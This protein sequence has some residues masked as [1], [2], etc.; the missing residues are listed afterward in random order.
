MTL[1]ALATTVQAQSALERRRPGA[2]PRPAPP[3]IRAE[4]IPTPP[5]TP[6]PRTELPP[7]PVAMP[8]RWRLVE[9]IG[10]NERWWDPYNQNTF[11]A[12]R[13]L[14][15]DHWFLNLNLLSASLFEGRGVPT[16]VGNQATDRPGELDVFGD[17][18][19][20]TIAETALFGGSL[21]KGDTTF[22]PPDYEFRIE[23]GANVNYTSV[24]ERGAINVNPDDGTTRLDGHIG[25][26]ELF[27]D[28]HLWNKSDDFDFDSLRVGIQAFNADFRG[29]LFDDR[30]LGVRLFGNFRKNRLQ[31]NLAW[32]R[33]LEKD[34]N[35]GLNRVFDPRQDDVFVANAFFQDL[36]VRGFQTEAVVVYNR[37]R[38]G[39][40]AFHFNENGFLERPAS[41]GL[42]RPH[43]YDVVYVG[44]GGDGHVGRL[45]LTAFAYGAFG[46]DEF[47]SIAGRKQ[48]LRAYLLASEASVDFD[49]YRV[50]VFAL[51]ASGDDDPFDGTATG[52]DAIFENPNFAGG[53]T[54]FFQRQ[55]VPLTGG[56]GVVLS[57]RNSLIP[58]LRSSKEQ[59]Q[60]SFVNPGIV[61][62]GLGADF[63][64][65]PELRLTTNVS[66]VAFAETAVLRTLRQ[67]RKVSRELGYDLSAAFVYRPWFIQ[68]V[69][70]RLS[71]AVLVPGAG[72]DDLYDDRYA[73]L[74][75]AFCEMVLTY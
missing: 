18:N 48:D 61:L 11:K 7:P 23:L 22:L 34:T 33:R 3:V 64:L 51:H 17:G 4:I 24:A 49:W 9:Q 55:A 38:E 62:V 36:P 54:S 16:A 52:F 2:L 63:D 21:I 6:T 60:S 73:V 15:G 29:F 65:L 8:D 44:A 46:R 41:V 20:W 45:N 12:D 74:Y 30:Q 56:G 26:Q 13:P 50:K 28:K 14:F 32:F 53:D 57:G 72:F 19:Q 31:Y 75:S 1:H 37:N 69:A 59:G 58:A 66:R 43:D 40:Q 71:G 67:Q 27:V 5:P 39:D 10:V 68:N 35:S 42:E 70:L 25:F 47:N